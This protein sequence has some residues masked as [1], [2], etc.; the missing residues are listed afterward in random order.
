M[1]PGALVS[2]PNTHTH[3]QTKKTTAQNREREKATAQVHTILP[4]SLHFPFFAPVISLALF[5]IISCSVSLARRE[6]SHGA[7]FKLSLQLRV[8]NIK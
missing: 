4:A 1:P 5:S 7:K 3:T 6:T 2:L 8:Y